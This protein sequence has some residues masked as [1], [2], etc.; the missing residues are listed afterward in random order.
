MKKRIEEQL[1]QKFFDK[2]ADTFMDDDY[3]LLDGM[4]EYFASQVKEEVNRALELQREEIYLLIDGLVF[5]NKS[6]NS[7]QL[8]D[9]EILSAKLKEAK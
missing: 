9:F 5:D 4:A 7:K 2:W 1:K 6:S 8:K 3:P